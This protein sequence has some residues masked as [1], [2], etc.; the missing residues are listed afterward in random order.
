[1]VRE[2]PMQ[3]WQ[4][5]AT[6]SLISALHDARA[7]STLEDMREVIGKGAAWIVRTTNESHG[8]AAS[9]MPVEASAEGAR[10]AAILL[11][12]LG[13]NDA[14]AVFNYD[15]EVRVVAQTGMRGNPEVYT[16][17]PEP[18]MR[19]PL[20]A[21][22]T[23]VMATRACVL[24][25]LRC[26]GA[27]LTWEAFELLTG[28]PN[29]RY[30]LVAHTDVNYSA[31]IDCHTVV[32]SF[33]WVIFGPDEPADDYAVPGMRKVCASVNAFRPVDDLWV[34]LDGPLAS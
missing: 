19:T 12:D 24:H 8:G 29:D 13:E 31:A 17:W 22:V 2:T 26:R 7:T 33:R 14:D 15:A 4:A 32:Y 20:G 30:A 34:N 1:M 9:M 28:K 21:E 11:P 3:L 10:L 5:R 18:S 23:E 6:G 25:Y 16:W 27:E